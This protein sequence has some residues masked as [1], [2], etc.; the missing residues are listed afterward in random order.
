[1]RPGTLLF[2]FVLAA[3]AMLG[4]TRSL[5]AGEFL[6]DQ[7]IKRIQEAQEID[8]RV[9][10]YMEA[11]EFRLKTAQE[12]LS[13]VESVEG[14]PLEFFSPEEML[15]GYY[16]I[17]KSVMLNL[18]DAYQEPYADLNKIKS[19]LKSLRKATD[20]AG[21]QLEILK[22]IAEDNKKEELWNLVNQAMDITK[23]AHEG[24]V[25]GLEK[26]AEIEERRRRR[27]R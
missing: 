26:I 11:A 17:L 12:R 23:G 5:P 1:M 21:H 25:S 27:R 18:D 15:D 9:K 6:T 8:K 14:D 7:E 2:I 3:G 13:G 16:R 24:A 20:K 22:R 4:I 19:G 10:I